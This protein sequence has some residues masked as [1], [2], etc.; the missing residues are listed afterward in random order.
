[1]EERQRV[2]LYGQSVIL[3]AVQAS[4]LHHPQLEVVS[5]APPATGQE[6]AGLAPDVMFFDAGAGCPAPAF[7]LLHDRPD[8][9]LIG[10]DASSAEMMVLSSYPVQA[11][12]TADLVQVILNKGSD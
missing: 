11:L 3:G 1:M 4:L 12:S 2:V 7:S 8:L 10:L 9:L 5:V 6:L